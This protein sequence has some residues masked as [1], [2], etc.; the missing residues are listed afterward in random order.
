M[1]VVI[2]LI[3]IV[4]F[5]VGLSS[6]SGSGDDGTKTTPQTVQVVTY[7]TPLEEIPALTSYSPIISALQDENIVD[8]KALA[9]VLQNEDP[10]TL[11]LRLKSDDSSLQ[12]EQ[13]L[14]TIKAVEFNVVLMPLKEKR[15]ITE[16]AFNSIVLQEKSIFALQNGSLR[17]WQS[18]DGDT[19][20][21]QAQVEY[22][23]QQWIAYNN[24]QASYLQPELGIDEFIALRQAVNSVTPLFVDL[25]AAMQ[26]VDRDITSPSAQRAAVR[27]GSSNTTLLNPVDEG[28]GAL[29]DE[30]TEF[31]AYAANR[32]SGCQVI[33]G[34]YPFQVMGTEYV[35]TL[36]D[37]TDLYREL[38]TSKPLLGDEDD[39]RYFQINEVGLAEL[40]LFN[41]SASAVP[42]T[43]EHHGRTL[44][45]TTLNA[46]TTIKVYLPVSGEDLC[47]PYYLTKDDLHI[48]AT[49]ARL[50]QPTVM[51]EVYDAQRGGYDL[52]ATDTVA[53]D[54]ERFLHIG[55]YTFSAIDSMK[56]VTR[57]LRFSHLSAHNGRVVQ[58]VVKSPSGK[59]YILETVEDGS[60][61]VTSEDGEWE[62]FVFPMHLLLE[63]P[64]AV[65]VD[66]T[67]TALYYQQENTMGYR[68]DSY[69]IRL[70]SMRE[71]Y[72][73]KFMIAEME[74][75]EFSHDG[76]DDGA[77]EVTI[78]LHTN[79]AP[80]LD[81]GNDLETL[82]SGDEAYSAYR[83]WQTYGR[84][85]A[86]FEPNNVCETQVDGRDKLYYTFVLQ[87]LGA[88]V[89][90]EDQGVAFMQ[91]QSEV[92]R[93]QAFV[94]YGQD[95][96]NRLNDARFRLLYDTYAAIYD[97]WEGNVVQINDMTYPRDYH[98][99]MVDVSVDETLEPT[100]DNPSKLFDI[101]PVIATHIP[102]FALTKERMA[103]TSLPL[104]FEYSAS[105]EDEVD[106]TAQLFAVAKL[107]V[108]Q[109]L[110]IVT[111]NYADLICNTVD[112]MKE[113]RQNE[114]NGEDDPLGEADF[115]LNR[116]S[117]VDSFYGMSHET[118]YAFSI[119]GLA[120]IP[121]YYTSYD[122]NLNIASLVCDVSGA[123]VAGYDLSHTID[124]LI[125]G[126]FYS[127][128]GLDEIR[129]NTLAGV[130]S[131]S[132]QYQ[133]ISDAFDLLESGEA[134]ATTLNA[135]AIAA[136]GSVFGNGIDLFG[137]LSDMNSDLGGL[138]GEGH[139]A[140]RS[141]AN[142]FFSSF[143]DR[144]TRAKIEVKEVKA[145]P[146]V[147]ANVNLQAVTIL[148][149][150]EDGDAEVKLRTRVGLISDQKP[151]YQ[152]DFS[153]HA[154]YMVDGELIYENGSEGYATLPNLPFKGYLLRSANYNGISDGQML[155]LGAP[156]SL[157]E[158]SY[159]AHNN[160]AAIYVEI[161]LYEGDGGGVDD[162]MIGVFSRT[163]YLEDLYA[164]VDGQRWT[165]L[166]DNRYRLRVENYPVYDK[167]NLATSVELLDTKQRDSQM[168]HNLER[169]KE[170][171]A[172]VSFDVEVTLGAY[173]DYG[174]VDLNTAIV[175]G[176]PN[177]GKEPFNLDLIDV[178]EI[179]SLGTSENS[180]MHLYDVDGQQILIY[181]L[182]H[183][184]R[185]ADIDDS[186][187]LSWRTA[188]NNANL[189][190]AYSDLVSV[191]D[192]SEFIRYEKVSAAAFVDADHLLIFNRESK[193]YPNIG[194]LVVTT[195]GE[196]NAS[197]SVTASYSLGGRNPVHMETVRIDDTTIRVYVSFADVAN[198]SGTIEVYE[199]KSDAIVKKST[200]TT[201]ACP[202]DILLI[203][204]KTLLVKS[205]DMVHRTLD[206]Q[207]S[208]IRDMYWYKKQYLQLYE[209][210][211]DNS[212]LQSTA[213]KQ[214]D[215][216]TQNYADGTEDTQSV[217]Q[218]R[219]T[220]RMKNINE[221]Q[222]NRIVKVYLGTYRIFD[223]QIET[224]ELIN[225]NG[226]YLFGKKRL[227]ALGKTFGVPVLENPKYAYYLEGYNVYPSDLS[228]ENALIT[229]A[230]EIL[231]E[232][233]STIYL[234]RQEAFL[235]ARYLVSVGK[236]KTP[237]RDG[238]HLS[239]L[240]ISD[241]RPPQIVGDLVGAK[242]RLSDTNDL[243][244]S[245]TIIPGETAIE[246]LEVSVSLNDIVVPTGY[247]GT[248]VSE[249]IC[250]PD[251]N[252]SYNCYSMVSV[253]TWSDVDIILDQ[254]LLIR[255][256]DD[257]FVSPYV[258]DETVSLYHKPV[259][260]IPFA[261][262]EHGVEVWQTDG[263][264][265]G[266][267]LVADLNPDGDGI[268]FAPY[269]TD[270]SEF[271]P[272]G[273]NYLFFATI[274]DEK[275][276][277]KIDKR[278]V[279]TEVDPTRSFVSVR[280]KLV[281]NNKLYF[282]V[283]SDSNSYNNYE[284][285][286]SDGTTVGTT[287]VR[288]MSD[289]FK[290]MN[291][292]DYKGQLYF[293]VIT[294]YDNQEE[295][296]KSDG[297]TVGTTMVRDMFDFIGP[298]TVAGD[299]LYFYNENWSPEGL[300]VSDGTD[301]G[302]TLLKAF[303]DENRSMLFNEQTALNGQFYYIESFYNDPAYDYDTVYELWKSDGTLVGTTRVKLIGKW[304]MQ[305]G[306]VTTS[307]NIYFFGPGALWKS[308]GTV[309]G[310]G[311][312]V[313]V[314]TSDPDY[315][316]LWWTIGSNVR[317][318][319]GKIY[320]RIGM[321]DGFALFMGD[322]AESQVLYEV[323]TERYDDMRLYVDR[324]GN[325]LLYYGEKDQESLLMKSGEGVEQVIKRTVR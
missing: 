192:E 101:H 241:Y 28:V 267:Q 178:D 165:H 50:Q 185:V 38:N 266:T 126:D 274:S 12:A 183:G 100:L 53:Y 54:D 8:T 233:D 284:L 4:M 167:S 93:R 66:N 295:L 127:G 210:Q 82:F 201:L 9:E 189:P 226:T 105:D 116:F 238:S 227:S 110:A 72:L 309:A 131:S 37:G 218:V 259:A 48:T 149:N 109:A 92:A 297:T 33:K 215:L 245:F 63:D 30:P 21:L 19:L 271:Y 117:N 69:E 214:L 324:Y 16:V 134:D 300:W 32:F 216:D 76:E 302:T 112:T 162:D 40:I 252:G 294:A 224:M 299:N 275:R 273:D 301:A 306:F 225:I 232:V 1:R 261:D 292:V 138:G 293:Q 64:L 90:S 120:T 296:W 242:V 47:V 182:I 281:V 206:Y 240:R 11:F 316:A 247:A 113:M 158:A 104:S 285:W 35:T 262:A 160:L 207:N 43:L 111:Q 94:W 95:L 139:N 209:L 137:H 171:S 220:S 99:G 34:T 151:Q 250:T 146:I 323:S 39:K 141:E 51:K 199:I 236:I 62:L 221:S 254:E 287:M 237:T 85:L 7:E 187:R 282:L 129:N 168:R 235:D 202:Q 31:L 208:Y 166:G 317:I 278:G 23:R 195:I 234:M 318:L 18:V 304:R 154:P 260:F 152:G 148:D 311:E 124:S 277:M 83:C 204:A 268:Y 239:I 102:I 107:V 198:M 3:I 49:V 320:I 132:Q 289:N 118:Q 55:Y 87:A 169:L 174:V 128:L 144:K 74:S 249:V 15:E 269:G 27:L 145:M 197:V 150:F 36:Q 270:K 263:E 77:A 298:M 135:L 196:N 325:D 173:V 243:N 314:D 180:D 42:V 14:A 78:N 291:M 156:L 5:I 179:T 155:P 286:V 84:E 6:C 65:D 231:N 181:D 272:V 319:N 22:D 71:S 89:M 70:A 60:L 177:H 307:T 20:S 123:I 114:I 147:S 188:I 121:N 122:R 283:Q 29:D 2:Q 125:S 246:D 68:S 305:E 172:L 57:T 194:K 257:G 140:M 276:L 59:F 153:Q 108:N 67:I 24:E 157:Y 313:T 253:D 25:G 163:F 322:P 264:A 97:E 164:Y 17:R 290:V 75:A 211:D 176:D 229:P 303:G 142:Y 133:D 212:T 280:E 191:V 248:S 193:S 205:A 228:L 213:L 255:V 143:D 79:M 279:I 44:V 98:Y 45:S 119:S 265:A 256:V 88:P 91:G 219:D 115:F 81:I 26:N 10:L 251:Q 310:T 258:T 200:H 41:G 130:D 175:D 288:D 223:S 170:P 161:G 58:Y 46:N 190:T 103:T 312:A 222:Y 230:D 96:K 13:L 136:K 315:N 308:D 56:S 203:D 244:V 184:L 61:E 86:L 52:L 159:P 217:V 186:Y 106:T 321:K 73:K 80:R